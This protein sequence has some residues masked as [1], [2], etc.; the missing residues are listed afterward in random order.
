MDNPRQFT[1]ECEIRANVIEIAGLTMPELMIYDSRSEVRLRRYFEPEPG[2]FIA[3]SRKVIRR[4]LDAGYEPLSLLFDR[5]LLLA[6]EKETEE[7]LNRCAAVPVYTA[8]EDVLA[9][10]TGFP[11]TQG[12]L[13]AMRRRPLPEDAEVCAGASR[14]AVLENITNQTNIGA[15]FRSAAALGFDAV[16]LTEGCCDPLY[17]RAIRVSMGTVFQIP[18]TYLDDTSGVSCSR[19]SGGAASVS[20]SRE[21][22]GAAGVS[23]SQESDRASYVSRLREMGFATVAMALKE[24]AVRLDDPRLAAEEKLAVLL[25]NE[26]AGLRASTIAACDYTVRIPM[27]HG[28][29]SLNAAAAGAVVFWQLGRSRQLR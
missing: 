11:L 12:V 2:F 5:R 6:E 14:I 28:V 26:N 15:V 7:I 25:G 17:R 27:A 20:C 18:W 24:N 22:G 8:G 16:L 23:C 3:E 4:A 13:C 19:E 29:D 1:E 10:L 21:S 9:Q